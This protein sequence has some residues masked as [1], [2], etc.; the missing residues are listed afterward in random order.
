RVE[1]SAARG[2]APVEQVVALPLRGRYGALDREPVAGE[3][4][5]G[6]GCE[7]LPVKRGR[8]PRHP[9]RGAVAARRTLEARG[10]YLEV[11]GGP[12]RLLPAVEYRH[13][14]LERDARPGAVRGEEIPASHASE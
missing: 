1:E 14:R 13:A 5:D 8:H 12:R 2:H 7:H 3:E 11:G 6:C 10:L 9:V 4:R